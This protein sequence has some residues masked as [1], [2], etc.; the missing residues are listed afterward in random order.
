M[1]TSFVKLLRNSGFG[2]VFMVGAAAC[3]FAGSPGNK[4]TAVIEPDAPYLTM[5][6]VLTPAPGKQDEAIRL[7]QAGMDQEMSRQPGFISASIHKSLNS[8]NVVVYAQ[9]KDQ[10]SVDA[11]VEV[12][13]GGGA[14]NMAEVFSVAQPDYHPYSVVSVHLTHS[15]DH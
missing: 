4:N 8:D 5:I 7:L 15:G 9:W 1:K 14:P 2:F 3:A 12:I 13:Q 11:A 10:A 6:N